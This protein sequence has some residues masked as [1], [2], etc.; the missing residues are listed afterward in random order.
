LDSR[1]ESL[2][3]AAVT[4][5]NDTT[6]RTAMGRWPRDAGWEDVGRVVRAERGAPRGFALPTSG[7]WSPTWRNRVLT[8]PV[9]RTFREKQLPCDTLIYLGTGF[10][11]SG[12]NTN[13]GEF[14]WDPGNIP[15]P[16]GLLNE[17]HDMKF[18]VVVHVVLEGRRLT[19]PRSHAPA[20]RRSD[21]RG[22]GHSR[23]HVR[24]QS[25]WDSPLGRRRSCEGAS[26]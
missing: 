17:L 25:H 15:D 11:P 8:N 7:K 18:R 2:S 3:P 23:G 6:V 12:W 14:T 1:I 26:P 9:A 20:D 4:V 22:I 13:N 5:R 16:E 24:R 10:T 21:C 19:A